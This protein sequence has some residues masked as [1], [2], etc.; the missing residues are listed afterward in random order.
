M[1]TLNVNEQISHVV[2]K[3]ITFLMIDLQIGKDFKDFAQFDAKYIS[4]EE[5]RSCTLTYL[6][7]R[8]IGGKTMFDYYADKHLNLDRKS[9]RLNSSH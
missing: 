5:K 8:K 2:D 4:Q 6:Y 1:T 7:S 3:I 9:T